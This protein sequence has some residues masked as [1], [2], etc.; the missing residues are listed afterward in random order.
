MAISQGRLCPAYSHKTVGYHSLVLAYYLLDDLSSEEIS[1]CS[2]MKTVHTCSQ[3]TENNWVSRGV[4]KVK[5]KLY[6]REAKPD[7]LVK[8]ISELPGMISINCLLML[9]SIKFHQWQLKVLSN[10]K[11]FK[12]IRSSEELSRGGKFWRMELQRRS[13]EKVKDIHNLLI[14]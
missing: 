11:C 7:T 9:T 4:L 8:A 12:L 2:R 10:L 13:T 5:R 1:K 6:P 3:C 14:S